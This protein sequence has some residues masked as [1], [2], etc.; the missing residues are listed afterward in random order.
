M[1]TLSKLLAGFFLFITGI[2]LA[3]P[4]ALPRFT[5]EREAAAQHFVKKQLPELLPLLDDL[6]KHN[7]PHYEQEIREIFQITEILADLLDEPKR[8]ELELKFWKTEN[9]ALVIVA[10]LSNAKVEERTK[11]VAQLHDLAKELVDLDLQSMEMYV[12]TLEKDLSEA[13][14]ELQRSRENLDKTVKDRYE[15]LLEKV[16]KRKK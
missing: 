13:K 2:V 9:R 10:K 1:T 15:S 14:E 16:K 3:A 12:E 4:N 11:L 5:E 7:R 8:H 6:K